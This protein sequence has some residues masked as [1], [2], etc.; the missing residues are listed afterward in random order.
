VNL[1]GMTLL[2]VALLVPGILYEVF[3][4]NIS[5]MLRHRRCVEPFERAQRNKS[6]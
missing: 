3:E 2:R 5:T 1:Y 6:E 4:T